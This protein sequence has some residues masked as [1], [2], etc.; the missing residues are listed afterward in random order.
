M[1]SPLT[2]IDLQ[3]HLKEQIHFL[4]SSSK[5]YDNGDYGEAKRMA[6]SLRIL[7]HDTPRSHSLLQQLLKKD[8][9]FYNTTG[10]EENETGYPSKRLYFINAAHAGYDRVTFEPILDN[11]PPGDVMSKNTFEFWWNQII[12]VADEK[13]KFSRRK[14]VLAVS[15]QDGGAHVAPKLDNQFATLKRDKSL[16]IT[17]YVYGRRVDF[18]NTSELATIRQ[19]T[20]EVL[21]TLKEEF[22]DCF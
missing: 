13:S 19:I 11:R 14:I 7:L 3:S 21:F 8:L 4:I 12:L 17:T 10:V 16:G 5:G 6:V 15:N 18:T 9:K 22:P 20:Y 1:P 2:P